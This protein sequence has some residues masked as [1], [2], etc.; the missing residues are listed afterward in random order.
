VDLFAAYRTKIFRDKIGF[1][2]QLNVQNLGET[3][4]LEPIGAFPDGSISTYRIVDPQKFILSVG[5]D[6]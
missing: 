6:L 2:V 4:R 5:F 1:T 3:G